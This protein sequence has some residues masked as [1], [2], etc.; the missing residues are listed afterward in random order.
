MVKA[1]KKATKAIKREK[2]SDA[3]IYALMPAFEEGKTE[4]AAG[5]K[6]WRDIQKR[7]TDEFLSRK[8]VP[9]SISATI[10][11]AVVTVT[12]TR[13]SHMEYDAAGIWKALSALQRRLAFERNMDLNKLSPAARKKVLA[14]L[15][16]EEIAEVTSYVLN[17][18]QLS[19]AV[20]DGKIPAKVIAPFTE[21]KFNAPYISVSHGTGE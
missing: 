16:K 3:D 14:V 21:E 19:Q 5:K 15:S 17:A 1:T 11:D 10:K 7:V 2:L 12:M 13:A 9:K 8:P 6:K 4:E 18:D 20:Q